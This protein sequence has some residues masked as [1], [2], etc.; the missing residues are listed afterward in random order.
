M[1]R[2]AKVD[3][4]RNKTIVVV[5]SESGIAIFSNGK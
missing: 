2:V 1:G 5:C 3:D 4:T